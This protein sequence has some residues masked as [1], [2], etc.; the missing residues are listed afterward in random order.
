MSEDRGSG[1]TFAETSARERLQAVP[2]VDLRPVIAPPAEIATPA[3][4]ETVPDSVGTQAP[5]VGWLVPFLAGVVVGAGGF[6][7]VLWLSALI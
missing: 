6:Y 1:T 7:A 5:G 3:P 4:Q 2:V